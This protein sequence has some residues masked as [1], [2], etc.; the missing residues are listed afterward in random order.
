MFSLHPRWTHQRR[1][2]LACKLLPQLELN[3]LISHRFPVEQAAEA[4]A[5]VDRH[6]DQTVQVLLTY[7]HA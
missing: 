4:F 6:A 1:L 2:Q 5:L 3:S 7:S